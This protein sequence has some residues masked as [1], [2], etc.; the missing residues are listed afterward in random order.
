MNNIN[1]ALEVN[2]AS[3]LPFLNSNFEITEL[4]ND[5]AFSEGPV[6]HPDGFLLFSDIPRNTIYKVDVEG[7]KEIFLE[8]S[9]W[10]GS[11]KESLSHMIG[12]NA[13]AWDKNGDLL[14]CQ[15]GNHGIALLDKN[16]QI[17]SFISNYS[18]KPFNSPNDLVVNSRGEIFFTDPPYGL[19]EEKLD[20]DKF[21]PVAGVYHWN[22]KKNELIFSDLKFPNGICLSPD[23]KYLYVCSNRKQE[24]FLMRFCFVEGIIVTEKLCEANCDGLKCDSFGNLY[25]ANEAGILIFSSEGKK[26]GRIKLNHI[27]SNMNWG[28]DKK[29]LFITAREAVYMIRDLIK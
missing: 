17:Q 11:G 16:K 25:L 29:T 23:E 12:S 24:P 20:P 9:G 6:W 21:Q 13:L 15:H 26:L 10:S 28:P 3:S 27:P 1:E 5:C 2:D 18:N 4:C 19:K 8:Q 14:I 22:G 7:K